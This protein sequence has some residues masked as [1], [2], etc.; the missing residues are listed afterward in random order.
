MPGAFVFE[1]SGPGQCNCSLAKNYPWAF[2]PRLG[3]A[4]QIDSKTVV[5]AGWGIIYGQTGIQGAGIATSG[6]AASNPAISPG[7]GLPIITLANG[8][9][10]IPTW[11]N[12]SPGVLPLLPTGNQTLPTAPSAVGLLDA[13]AGRPPR[14][15]Q[16][17]IG[18]E[19]E[20][21]RDLIVEVAYVGNRGVWW[22]S[23]Q[24]RDINGISSLILASRGLSPDNPAD[25]TL[26]TSTLGSA[27]ASARGFNKVPYAG[28][29]TNNTVAQSLRP[30]PQFGVIPTNG[31]P[32]G[33]TWYDSLQVKVNKRLSGG[34][35]VG[36]AFT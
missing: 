3:I 20:I 32:L 31:A 36:S 1:G 25:V 11:P 14:Q 23:P 4:Y 13:N 26:L 35:N 19:R 30:F 17:S 8:I 6:V 16:W 22:A 7:Q 2:A 18:I 9:P 28:F 34:L 5:R 29:S 24:M 10:S 27:T 15:N 21:T 33:K 12:L